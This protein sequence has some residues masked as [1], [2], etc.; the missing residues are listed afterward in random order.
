MKSGFEKVAIP[1]MLF[2]GNYVGNIATL[3]QKEIKEGETIKFSIWG[4]IVY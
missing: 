4:L 1:E 3:Y 2:F